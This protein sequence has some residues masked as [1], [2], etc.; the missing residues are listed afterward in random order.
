MSTFYVQD[1]FSRNPAEGIESDWFD[2]WR[3]TLQLLFPRQHYVCT[4]PF[5]LQIDGLPVFK[6]EDETAPYSPFT[7]TFANYNT[8]RIVTFV[9]IKAQY[10]FH[11]PAERAD[12]DA[13]MRRRFLRYRESGCS[14]PYMT[15]VSAFGPHLAFYQ[16]DF[17]RNAA[18]ALD[19]G[20]RCF[21]AV[22]D[23]PSENWWNVDLQRG[24]WN[25]FH[26]F[27]SGVV[28]YNGPDSK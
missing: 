9:D 23:V 14:A 22:A 20:K 28:S 4:P 26:M 2:A 6:D 5:P 11:D 10:A 17:R 12:A 27:L 1:L 13:R 21:H 16:F 24:D 18:A 15:G 3:K 19:L 8:H 25:V 7:V